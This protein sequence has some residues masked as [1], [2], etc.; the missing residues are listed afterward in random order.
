MLGCVI[1][2]AF[3]ES[4]ISRK[5]AT[6][7]RAGSRCAFLSARGVGGVDL[8]EA[9]LPLVDDNKGEQSGSK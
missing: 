8:S 7:L 4:G 1:R 3:S 6:L 5:M 9:L 2:R